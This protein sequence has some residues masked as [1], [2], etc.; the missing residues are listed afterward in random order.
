MNTG[1]IIVPAELAVAGMWQL[2]ENLSFNNRFI[3]QHAA[4][5][6][7]RILADCQPDDRK[8]LLKVLKD[9]RAHYISQNAD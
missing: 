1:K 4:G 9:A 3:R 7:K 5:R 6:I 8:S 2:A